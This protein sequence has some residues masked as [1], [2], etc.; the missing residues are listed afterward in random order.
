M[1]STQKITYFIFFGFIFLGSCQAFKKVETPNLQPVPQS[2]V[3]NNTNDT[4]TIASISWKDF[5]EDEFLER[6]IDT[7]LANNQD[8]QVAL[9]RVERASAQYTMSRAAL[10]PALELRL[11][12]GVDRF[13]KYTM[14]SV[15]NFD[16]NLSNNITE[17]LRIPFPLTPDYFA[18]FRTNWEIDIWGKLKNQRK[19]DLARFMATK[20]GVRLI[21]T[22]LVSQVAY[23]YYELLASDANLEIIRKNI[24]LQEQAVEIINIQKN[25][26]QATALAVQQF[27]A[28]LLRTKAI[29]A[30]MLQ[31]V[32]E[33]ENIMRNL[34]GKFDFEIKRSQSFIDRKPPISTKVG[35]PMQLLRNR[36]DIRQAEWEIL[37]AKADL[38]AAQMA[39]LPSFN[40]TAQ[41]AYNAFSTD[42]LFAPA[43]LA[44]GFWGGLT[45]PLFQKNTVKG[46]YKIATARQK[47]AY[48]NYQK[49][50]IHAYTE[51]NT[52]LQALENLEKVFD[53]KQQEVTE[54]RN[55]VT[56]SRD[57]FVAGYATYLEVIT[58]QKN[59][60]EAELEMHQIVKQKLQNAVHLYR[61]TGGG[62]K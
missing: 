18:G 30:Q 54:L 12:G 49:T 48:L 39:F 10:L 7:A 17:D 3:K 2:F 34:L 31:Q 37:A 28:Q 42:L 50:I 45:A 22:L 8:K 26:G 57:L 9:Q 25:A 27:N 32:I 55:A 11:S 52:Q 44:Y 21:Q 38:R 1:L 16:T 53:F 40:I 36:P 23:I 41:L 20:E 33:L 4:T 29:E 56:T 60:L 5:F 61:A 47:E 14:N 58:A 51:V 13:G 6:L 46:N 24:K 59:T 35:V 62:A 43:S 19:A 15:G